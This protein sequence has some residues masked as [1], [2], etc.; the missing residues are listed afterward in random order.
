M[1]RIFDHTC[2]LHQWNDVNWSQQ[3]NIVKRSKW[4]LFSYVSQTSRVW[5]WSERYVT[6]DLWKYLLIKE[7]CWV[8]LDHSYCLLHLSLHPHTLDVWLTY[9]NSGHSY[10]ALQRLFVDFSWR[11]ST[12]EDCRCG[13]KFWTLYI[14]YWIKLFLKLPFAISFSVFIFYINHLNVNHLERFTCH[15]EFR[16]YPIYTYIYIYTYA[17]YFYI[18]CIY[19]YLYMYIIHNVSI[20]WLHDL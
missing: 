4:P 8:K 1:S 12:V 15:Y 14:F 2:S 10:F 5:G 7:R 11:R 20:R 9:E 19:K 13:R 3:I 16:T 18:P 6:C 17:Q